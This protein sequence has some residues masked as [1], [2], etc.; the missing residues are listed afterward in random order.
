MNTVLFPGC[1]LDLQIFRG[2][3]P[4]H[5]R[6]LHEKKGEGFGVVCILDGEEVGIAPEGY[7]RVGCEARI[8]DFFPA[9]QWSAGHSRAGRAAFYRP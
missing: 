3:L 5:D 1:I 8:T 6:A 9:G 2:A 4:R 7:A